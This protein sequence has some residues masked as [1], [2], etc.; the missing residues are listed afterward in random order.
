MWRSSTLIQGNCAAVRFKARWAIL[1]KRRPCIAPTFNTCRPII[2]P[3][4]QHQTSRFIGTEQPHSSHIHADD[5]ASMLEH[6]SKLET[7][8]V[9][10]E[11]ATNMHVQAKRGCR[12]L[13]LALSPMLD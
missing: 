8:L 9:D 1:S 12:S 7:K 2:Y 5:F 4:I 10:K 3:L 6:S 13:G 11:I